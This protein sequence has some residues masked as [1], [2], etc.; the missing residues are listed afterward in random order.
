[1]TDE[2]QKPAI[3]CRP[4]FQGVAIFVLVFIGMLYYEFVPA[5]VDG[6]LRSTSIGLSGADGYYHIKMGWLYRTGEIAEAGPNFHWTRES[7]W[8]NAFSDKD[9]LFHIYLV[10]F[11]LLA[12]GPGDADGLI[13]GAKLA[14]SLLSAALVLV[15]FTVLRG[16]GVR[17]AW[18][19]ALGMMAVGGSYFVFRLNLCRSYVASVLFAMVGWLLMAKGQRKALFLLAVVYTL[20]YTASHLLL[21]MLLV[22]TT[23]ELFMGARPGSSRLRDLRGNG[24][25]AACIIGGIAVGC[26][27]HP[28]SLELIK[29]WW[30]QNV[31]V[32]AL[33]HKG[34]VAAVVDGIGAALGHNTDYGQ[35]VEIALGRELGATSGPAAIFG[36]PLIF[37]GPMFLP[38]LAAILGWRPTR[39]AVLTATIAVVFLVLYMVNTRFLE[40]AAPFMTLALGIWIT[41]LL[42]SDGY[43]GWVR[44]RPVIGR[45]LPISG[46]IIALIASTATW[47][48]AARAYV[49]RD[50]GDI[51]LAARWLHETKEAHGKVVWHDRWDNFTELIFFASECDYLIGLDPTFMVVHDREKY[52][53][54]WE[55]QRGKR[56]DFVGT[57]R[58]DFGAEYILANRSSSEFFYSRLHEEARAGKLTLCIRADD[59]SWS[60]Y[61]IN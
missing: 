23:M 22:R 36:T 34:S 42:S 18:I 61:R 27:L 17:Y 49:V 1:M 35:G 57:I 13:V 39:E 3:W 47:V 30:T 44:R 4:W 43:A 7:T 48:G 6:E 20:A 32:L 41:G 58:D 11:T 50:R 45:A 52:E 24:I 14:I 40:Y 21:A 19:F 28:Q 55:I 33:S 53:A 8:S 9:F 60:L 26:A 46:A 5:F 31:V 37:F 59:D 38:L 54:W 29:L 56:R 25:L 2:V 12:D 10:P 16:F 15:L 51:E